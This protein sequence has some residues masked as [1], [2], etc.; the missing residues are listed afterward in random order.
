MTE[1]EAATD[2]PAPSAGANKARDF[3][4]RVRL[5]EHLER[6]RRLGVELGTLKA[7]ALLLADELQVAIGKVDMI[8]AAI[9]KDRSG[10]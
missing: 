4:D 3:V 10:R 5:G 7:H 9:D 6:V 1:N 8:A 2:Q